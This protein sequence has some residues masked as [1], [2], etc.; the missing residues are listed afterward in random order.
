YTVE[1][2]AKE[3]EPG[4]EK[5]PDG[6]QWV[7]KVRPV[8]HC[9]AIAGNSFVLSAYGSNFGS[10][11]VILDGFENRRDP[12]LTADAIAAGLRSKFASVAPE[13][14]VNVFGAPAVP[15]LGRA[16]GFRIMIEDRGDVG[17]DVLQG[18]T[19]NLIEK[20]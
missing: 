12:K 3:G 9:N 18:Q 19:E 10:M 8:H 13:A 15:R 11:F 2:P 4:A 14:Q 17:P 16:G 20:G 6:D 1:L 7:R 5:K